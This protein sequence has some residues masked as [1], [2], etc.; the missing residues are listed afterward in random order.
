MKNEPSDPLVSVITPVYNGEE[1]LSECI[2]SVLA[3]TYQ[4]WQMTIINNCSTD[5]TPQIIQDYASKDSRIHVVNNSSF[6]TSLENQNNALKYISP[7]SKYCKILHTDDWL[8]PNCIEK[9]VA[10]SESHPN[11]GVVSSY[12]LSDKTVFGSGLHYKETVVPGSVPCRLWLLNNKYLFGNPS[13]L[14]IRSDLL[15]NC[16]SLY[17]ETYINTDQVA[18][19]DLLRNCDF[20]FIHEILSF[21]RIHD[22]QVSSFSDRCKTKAMDKLILIFKY[23]TDHLSEKELAQGKNLIW[24]RYYSDLANLFFSKSKNECIDYHKRCLS[25]IGQSF[26]KVLFKSILRRIQLIIKKPFV[27]LKL[28]SGKSAGSK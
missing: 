26:N 23:G 3:Q 24:S 8:L 20:G 1:Y 27:K 19:F 13:S 4:N 5:N 10:L 7:Q 2:D 6:L 14:L 12:V 21:M 28:I 17:D 15:L 16:D 25:S 11:V 9:M 18:C 22:E